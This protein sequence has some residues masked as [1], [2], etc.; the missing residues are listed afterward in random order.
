LVFEV[1]LKSDYPEFALFEKNRGQGHD[2]GFDAFMTGLVFASFS[3]YI[4]IGNIIA[5][6]LSKASVKDE[7][8]KHGITNNKR[9]RKCMEKE[10][11]I[12]I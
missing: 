8:L 10:L 1:D 4:E 7:L 2:A 3:K 9:N 5:P 12:P 6:E 11:S